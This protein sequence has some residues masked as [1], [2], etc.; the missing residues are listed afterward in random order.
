MYFSKNSEYLTIKKIG[1]RLISV[2]LILAMLMLAGCD[3]KK[4]ESKPDSSD[5]TPASSIT[6]S[7]EDTS[8][9]DDITSGSSSEN[10][11]TDDSSVTQTGKKDPLKGKYTYT[12][13]ETNN[14]NANAEI[15]P[16][17][18][19]ANLNNP[20]KG[21]F[22][23][24][25]DALREKIVNSPNTEKLYK[26]KGR[27]FYVS[28]KGDDSN[29]GLSPEEPIKSVDGVSGLG[30]KAGDAVLFERGAVFRM[31]TALLAESG[32]IYGSY[33]TG[34]KPKFYASPMNFADAVWTPSKKKN[35]WEL[36]WVYSDAGNMV[37]EHGKEIGYRKTSMRNMEKNTDF[38]QDDSTK[39]MYL[40]CDKGNPANVYE[41]IE[42][43]VRMSMITVAGGAK[44]TVVIDNLCLKY[45]GVHGIVTNGNGKNVTITNCELGYIGGCTTGG[46][47]RYG[48][49]IQFWN[50]AKNMNVKNN[51]I[52]Q[53]FDTA[54][55]WQ[56]NGGEGFKYEDITFTGNL[57]EYNN[58]D[59]E[60]WGGDGAEVK[61][62]DMS[63]NI[64][65]FTCLGWGTRAKDGGFRGY[66][67]A[68]SGC[69]T[70]NLVIDNITAKNNI[71][72]CQG[73]RI[74]GWNI[75]PATK[76]TEII[77]SGSK[78]YANSAYR[79]SSDVLRGF[80]DKDSDP[81]QT[82]ASNAEEFEKAMKMFDLTADIKW[83]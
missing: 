4:V 65:R 62:Y 3:G 27:K 54:F 9:D 38:F 75:T 25:A 41:S 56:G 31:Y 79:L 1:C 49:A 70:D 64:M 50:D 33:G 15:I 8:S 36:D 78:I 76:H 72:D 20:L 37:F 14:V 30:L 32:V 44:E 24:E 23:K 77:V 82:P 58:T 22:D 60:F 69:Y 19:T 5:K 66:E 13:S 39:K 28:P 17:G 51:W 73:S 71:F 45:G 43:G 68:I 12:Q 34:D 47:G 46:G 2:L 42:V 7:G 40:Y 83:F 29:S 18:N 63:D 35:V 6:S 10:T 52:Y 26:I 57:L 21:Y 55:S 11:S 59:I 74:I 16:T 81:N 67:G 80:K 61:N 48:N 53:T